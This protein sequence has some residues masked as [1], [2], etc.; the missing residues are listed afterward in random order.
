MTAA[1]GSNTFP[2]ALSDG[3]IGR[4]TTLLDAEL[5]F[6]S[7]VLCTISTVWVCAS[8][9][10]TQ[11]FVEVGPILPCNIKIWNAVEILFNCDASGYVNFTYACFK[12][13]E[14]PMR[15]AV[16]ARLFPF[17]QTY[18]EPA[19]GSYHEFE[20]SPNVCSNYAEQHFLRQVT[21]IFSL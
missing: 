14:I 3:C 19:C 5:P 7:R 20:Y 9:T 15:E 2:A 16:E 11:S 17:R 18:G 4:F 6:P 21:R 10:F 1:C 12:H 8:R 13:L